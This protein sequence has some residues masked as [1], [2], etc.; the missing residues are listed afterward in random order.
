MSRIHVE[1]KREITAPLERVYAFLADYQ[2]NRR[3][4]LGDDFQDY[5]VEQGG[6]GAGTVVAYQMRAGRRERPYRM[7]VEEPNKGRTLTEQDTGSSFRTTWMVSPAA[8][9]EKTLVSVESTWQGA[10]GIGGL[11]ERLFAP[12]ALRRVYSN[13]LERLAGALET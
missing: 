8:E 3:R 7:R 11:F 12:T 13:V 4:V 9:G 5:R 10:A 1:A 2:D 6:A